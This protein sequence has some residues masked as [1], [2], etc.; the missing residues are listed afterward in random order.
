MVKD[1]L[2]GSEKI[3][4][5]FFLKRIFTRK[6]SKINKMVMVIKKEMNKLKEDSST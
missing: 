5:D 4:M 3:M 2:L 6:L 1:L